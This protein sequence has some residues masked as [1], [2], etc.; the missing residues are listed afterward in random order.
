[1]GHYPPFLSLLV[2]DGLDSAN[3]LRVAGGRRHDPGQ[4]V[5]GTASA[6]RGDGAA[7]ELSAGEHRE[8]AAQA[9]Q[10]HVARVLPKGVIA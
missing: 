1:M 3:R 7:G 5:P 4:Q 9:R 10:G 2:V 8:G 6:C